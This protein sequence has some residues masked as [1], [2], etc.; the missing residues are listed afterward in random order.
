MW[1][2]EQAFYYALAQLVG[3]L[4]CLG[5]DYQPAASNGVATYLQT[6]R[7]SSKK[8]PESEPKRAHG[9]NNLNATLSRTAQRSRAEIA[10]LEYP[11]QLLHAIV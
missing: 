3:S 10:V 1:V 2:G 7:V 11:A 5:P 6:D 9:L 4:G 8:P